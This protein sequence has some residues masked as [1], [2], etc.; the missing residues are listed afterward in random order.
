MKELNAR[1]KEY[2]Q[3]IFGGRV[4]FNLV[5]RKLYS[6]D[7]GVIPSL[8]AP[9]FGGKTALAVVQPE[10]EEEIATLVKW[11]RANMLSLIPRGKATSGYGGVIPI[12]DAVVV[13]LYRLNKVIGINKETMTAEVQGGITWEALDREL[14][15]KGC[16]L[17]LYPTSY[18]SST[19]AGSS[20]NIFPS[21][22]YSRF[23]PDTSVPARSSSCTS[24]APR[25]VGFS[26]TQVSTPSSSRR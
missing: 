2:L 18:P 10:K 5:E 9:L 3:G 4:N 21:C 11:A 1:Q 8:M 15:K 20:R 19:A 6:H 16:G 17:R 12:N 7:I 14:K 26:F 22:S 23:R 24:V 13:D 25:S